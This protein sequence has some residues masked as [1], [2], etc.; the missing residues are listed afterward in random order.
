MNQPH[1]EFWEG[2]GKNYG[3]RD[4]F[5]KSKFIIKYTKY[6]RKKLVLSVVITIETKEL[7]G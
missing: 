7:L 5:L 1:L 2:G 4:V 3:N 6:A